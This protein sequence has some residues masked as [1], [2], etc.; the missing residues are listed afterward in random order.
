MAAGKSSVIRVE[1][2]VPLSRVYWGRRRNRAARAVRLLREYV[3]RHF[4][5]AKRV[6][7]DSEVNEYIWQRS[8]EK[9]PR[10]VK[11]IV[12]FDQEEGVA[13]VFLARD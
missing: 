2:V 10:R 9:P 12:S 8:I 11:V 13:K 1:H 6:V 4:K 7:I 5:K 3:K